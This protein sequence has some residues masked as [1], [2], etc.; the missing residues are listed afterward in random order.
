MA[1]WEGDENTLGDMSDIMALAVQQ[2]VYEVEWE[3]QVFYVVLESNSTVS[4]FAFDQSDKQ[5]SFNVTGSTGTTGFCNV[6]IPIK[7][8]DGAFIVLIDNVNTFYKLTL[9]ENHTFLHFLYSYSTHNVKIIG[10]TVIPEFPSLL[11]LPLFMTAT[12][13]AVLICRRKHVM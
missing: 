11:I 2:L 1:F 4:D 12:L 8:L 7:L 10:T 3:E 5:I 13:L 9:D 6:T